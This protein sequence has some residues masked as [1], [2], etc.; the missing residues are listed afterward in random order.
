MAESNHDALMRAYRECTVEIYSPDG[1]TITFSVSSTKPVPLPGTVSVITAYNPNPLTTLRCAQGRLMEQNRARQVELEQ[2]LRDRKLRFWPACNAPRTTFAEPSFA[3]FD[4]ALDD[5]LKLAQQ[6][7]QRAV[8]F[9][10]GG[11]ALLVWVGG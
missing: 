8:Y 6:F 2:I 7:G 10:E 1:K 3:I 11:R 9:I 5:A 4:L